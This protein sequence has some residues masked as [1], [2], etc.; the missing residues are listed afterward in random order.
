MAVRGI[1]HVGRKNFSL[2]NSEV[3]SIDKMAEGN[4]TNL[5]S[6][7]KGWFSFCSPIY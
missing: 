6:C 5:L 2:K 3:T 1:V 4:V 7:A